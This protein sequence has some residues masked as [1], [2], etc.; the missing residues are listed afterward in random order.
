MPGLDDPV[1][2]A[3]FGAPHGLRGEVRLRPL[4]DDPDVLLAHPLVAADG[5]RFAIT[6]LRPAKTVLIARVEGLRYRDEAEALNRLTLHLDRSQLPAPEEGEFLA[7]DLIGCAVVGEGG[8]ALGR[9]RSVP[10]F[11][12]GDL[13]EIE[14]PSSQGGGTWFLDFTLANVPE[15]DLEARRV[16]V[17]VPGEVSERDEAEGGGET[18]V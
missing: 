9:I 15:V 8:E 2:V 10:D 4:V 16:T 1:A 14:G 17:R 18:D 3:E 13:L 11:G 12:A 6:H 7:V 5:R